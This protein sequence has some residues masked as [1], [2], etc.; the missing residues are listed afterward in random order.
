MNKKLLLVLSVVVLFFGMLFVGC[1][2]KEAEKK[3]AKSAVLHYTCGMHPSIKVSPEEYKKGNTNCPICN[4][5]LVPVYAERTKDVEE[6]VIP[7][8]TLTSREKSLAGVA[9]EKVDYRH[10]IKEI[11]TVGKI[12]YDPELTIAEEEYITTLETY[13][14]ILK[15][16]IPESIERA[17]RLVDEAR[18]R[19]RLLGISKGMIEELEK[20]RNVHTNLILPEKT[21]WVYADVYEFEIGRVKEGQKISIEATAYPGEIFTGKIRAIDPVLNPKTRSVRVRAEI[22]NP[23]LKLKPDMYVNATILIHIGNVLSI[24]RD[25]VLDTGLRKI[26]YVDLGEGKYLAREIEIGPEAHALV[27]GIKGRF[28]PVKKGVSEGE[29]VVTRANFLIDSQSQLT[30]S[31]AA[32]AYGGALGEEEKEKMPAGHSMH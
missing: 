30:G 2:K 1:T 6:E 29:Q 19:L 17:K 3:E 24:P 12:A 8:V 25:A 18:Y 4:M 13:E 14:K 27:N 32:A 21:V 16:H 9:T 22:L 7:T 10:L 28:Y 23:G 26:V 31:A 20:T 11:V 5:G 15:S